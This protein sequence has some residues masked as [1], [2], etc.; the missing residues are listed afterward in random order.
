MGFDIDNESHAD[1]LVASSIH[2]YLYC[3]FYFIRYILYI[4]QNDEKL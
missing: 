1:V 2:D 4:V 3:A